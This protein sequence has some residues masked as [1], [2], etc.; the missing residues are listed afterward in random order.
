MAT[1]PSL[2]A[3][4]L[5]SPPLN[6]PTG[7]RAALAMTMSVIGDLLAG[8]TSIKNKWLRI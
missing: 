4:K 1:S 2:W 3:G 7:V 8:L 6:A 5:L